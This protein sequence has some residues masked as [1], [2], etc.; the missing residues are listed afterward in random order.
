MRE[1][2]CPGCG[3]VVLGDV[4]TARDPITDEETC[5]FCAPH[6]PAREDMAILFLHDAQDAMLGRLA[7]S[8]GATRRQEPPS[9]P[10]NVV[11]N[12]E[13][14]PTAIALGDFAKTMLGLL[15]EDAKFGSPSQIVRDGGKEIIDNMNLLLKAKLIESGHRES[16]FILAKEE[17]DKYLGIMELLHTR[18]V[19]A[20]R[21][22]LE[23][24]VDKE[25][26]RK[27]SYTMFW[28]IG[29]LIRTGQLARTVSPWVTGKE[30]PRF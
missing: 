19:Q 25:D 10:S 15:Y 30:A 22:L 28:H 5:L 9:R 20:H 26:A 11:I 29:S 23:A 3:V 16:P 21:R 18:Y 13:Q 12:P 4:A 27:R 7:P 24:A 6:D 14:G 8:L 2:V 17:T 1:F